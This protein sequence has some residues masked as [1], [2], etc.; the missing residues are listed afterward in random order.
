MVRE[1]K[2]R[3]EAA[4]GERR[5]VGRGCPANIFK[6]S[7]HTMLLKAATVPVIM[8]STKKLITAIYQEAGC[9]VPTPIAWTFISRCRGEGGGG[10][11]VGRLGW[12]ATIVWP[13]THCPGCD[14]DWWH[15]PQQTISQRDESLNEAQTMI[16]GS[17]GALYTVPSLTAAPT[18]SYLFA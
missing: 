7:T 13:G 12:V 2:G 15:L 5:E 3:E 14:E 9:F 18:Y 16:L 4:G 6:P 8:P 11:G 10:G 17:Y 1:R